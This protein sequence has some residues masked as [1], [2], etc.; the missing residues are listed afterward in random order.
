MFE[1]IGSQPPEAPGRPGGPVLGMGPPTYS[2]S[3]A[4]AQRID[5]SDAAERGVP[6]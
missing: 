1:L 5:T 6:T 4:M 3:W 2:W